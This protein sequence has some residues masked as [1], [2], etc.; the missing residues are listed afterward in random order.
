MTLDIGKRDTAE[1][2]QLQETLI[3]C[4]EEKTLSQRSEPDPEWLESLLSKLILSPGFGAVGGL[5][6]RDEQ[7]QH[8]DQHLPEIMYTPDGNQDLE[9]AALGHASNQTTEPSC[10]NQLALMKYKWAQRD[11]EM[12]RAAG[13]GD[14]F[15][16][17]QPLTTP[18]PAGHDELDPL[19]TPPPP[20]PPPITRDKLHAVI[21]KLEDGASCDEKL[22]VVKE[23]YSQ[24]LQEELDMNVP[25]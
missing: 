10:E 23:M 13:H 11:M 15:W 5:A 21:S 16:E 18:P 9:Y 7:P 1:A 24:I 17:E 14:D 4:T 2:D 3:Q 8:Q 12:Q 6:E 22:A 20:P 19:T 25:H